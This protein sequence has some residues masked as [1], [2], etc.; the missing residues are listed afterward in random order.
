[1]KKSSILISNKIQD[2][3]LYRHAIINAI[4][5]Y[6]DLLAFYYDSS[7]FAGTLGKNN[8]ICKLIREDDRDGNKPFLRATAMFDTASRA[9]RLSAE[10]FLMEREDHLRYYGQSSPKIAL[11][12]L[13]IG[14]NVKVRPSV[15][16]LVLIFD[17]DGEII[18]AFGESHD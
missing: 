16:N 14:Q 6:G 1:M 8:L 12:V 5:A 9:V 4:K 3:P 7:I 13:E 18:G 15:G 2:H 11:W 17:N 10:V